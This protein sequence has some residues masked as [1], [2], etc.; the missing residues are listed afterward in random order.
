MRTS[1][2]M[3]FEIIDTKGRKFRRVSKTSEVITETL[4]FRF[5]PPH[6]GRSLELRK[7]LVMYQMVSHISVNRI[8]PT[9]LVSNMYDPGEEVE[10]WARNGDYEGYELY[11]CEVGLLMGGTE[12]LHDDYTY[13]HLPTAVLE[14][15]LSALATYAFRKLCIGDGAFIGE[16]FND[17]RY[18]LAFWNQGV[19]WT[20]ETEEPFSSLV[21]KIRSIRDCAARELENPRTESRNYHQELLVHYDE[22]CRLRNIAPSEKALA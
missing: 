17:K 11:P 18:L 15:R 2:M 21:E 3:V 19:E 13:G 5:D 8:S 20:G 6:S 10:K 4:A 9:Y 16:G 22:Y 7:S 12:L 1:Q 14:C